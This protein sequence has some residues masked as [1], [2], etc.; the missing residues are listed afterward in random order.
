MI[1]LDALKHSLIDFGLFRVFKNFDGACRDGLKLT[2]LNLHLRSGNIFSQR[3]LIC[4]ICGISC[5]IESASVQYIFLFFSFLD[6]SLT[7][8]QL[9]VLL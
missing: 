7:E 8:D 5:S 2:F 9:Q 1:A 6:L 4:L 3:Q